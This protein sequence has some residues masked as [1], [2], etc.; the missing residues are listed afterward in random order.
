MGYSGF[1][2]GP[3]L[4]GVVAQVTNLQVALFITVA[5]ALII[6]ASARMVR[7]ADTY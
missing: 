6:A 5:A 7:A 4:I 1:L 2:A 3:P